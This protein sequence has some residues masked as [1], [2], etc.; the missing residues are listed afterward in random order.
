MWR[1]VL[2]SVLVF[3]MDRFLRQAAGSARSSAGQ[4]ALSSAGRLALSSAEQ[5]ASRSDGQPVAVMKFIGDV[6]RW[7]R[8]D[9]HAT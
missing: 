3:A 6:D 9:A 4:P 2:F 1:I 5:P 7:L 8:A